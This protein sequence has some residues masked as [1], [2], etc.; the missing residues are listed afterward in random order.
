MA[1]AALHRISFG[2]EDSADF[3]KIGSV[4]I[5]AAPLPLAL[6]IA[7]DT[8]VA[9]ARAL[10]SNFAA[11]SIAG[12]TV[13]VLTLL[14]YAYPVWRRINP[15]TSQ[16]PPSEAFNSMQQSLTG[17]LALAAAHV[18]DVAKKR[19]L[20]I[21]TAESCT[22]GML[23]TLLSEAPGASEYLHGGF[24]TYTKEN[25]TKVLG[26]SEHL[27][28][29]KSAVCTEVAVAM[30]EG[31]LRRSPADLAVAVTGVAGPEPD[32]DGNPVGRACIA[33][34]RR[35]YETSYFARNYGDIGR[36]AVR[37]RAVAD[38]LSELIRMADKD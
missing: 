33:V 32:E 7:L 3:L 11:A 15:G 6:G 9:I 19:N 17:D 38:A 18:L 14:W 22:A 37:Q 29:E 12:T 2:G 27:L 13:I 8:Y 35:G 23:S 36:D 31:A 10:G 34:A 24:V 21:V 4:F 25:K 16:S 5:V 1:P 30:A 28:A 26:V 20:T